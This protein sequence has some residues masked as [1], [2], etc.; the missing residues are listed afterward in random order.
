[1]HIKILFSKETFRCQPSN[2]NGITFS[3]L[4]E[5]ERHNLCKSY[6]VL[7]LI[8]I[9]LILFTFS[10]KEHKGKPT[11]LRHSILGDMV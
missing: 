1:M 6:N 7:N 2:F 11:L 3:S 8:S 4:W 5:T 9:V 10:K